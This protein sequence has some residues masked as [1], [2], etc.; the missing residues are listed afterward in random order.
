MKPL[1]ESLESRQLLSASLSLVTQ[2]ASVLHANQQSLQADLSSLTKSS[3]D[4]VKQLAADQHKHKGTGPHGASVL[5]KLSTDEIAGL[6]KVHNDVI[7]LLSATISGTNKI[8]ADI[9]QILKGSTWALQTKLTNDVA[10]LKTKTTALQTTL[11]TDISSVET[12]VSNDLNSLAGFPALTTDANKAKT[13]F[14]TGLNTVMTDLTSLT[15]T[16]TKIATDASA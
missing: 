4:A 15:T 2:D 13:T 9:R 1:I 14:T 3:N 12:M 16:I 8:I 5:K 6:H 11:S 10:A 7:A